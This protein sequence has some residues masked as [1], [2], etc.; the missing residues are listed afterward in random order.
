[1]TAS[2]VFILTRFLHFAGLVIHYQQEVPLWHAG[3]GV[4]TLADVIRQGAAGKRGLVYGAEVT[5]PGFGSGIRTVQQSGALLGTVFLQ[6]PCPTG[7]LR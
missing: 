4:P 6:V 1:M 7:S 2:S 5:M 3:P